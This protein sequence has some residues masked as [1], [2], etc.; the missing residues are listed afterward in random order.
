MMPISAFARKTPSA[1]GAIS[2]PSILSKHM[3][4]RKLHE[5]CT[6]SLPGP[7]ITGPVTLSGMAAL[8][9]VNLKNGLQSDW[10]GSIAK[11]NGMVFKASCATPPRTLANQYGLSPDQ[12]TGLALAVLQ[13][14]VKRSDF[15][16]TP[17]VL[18]LM[19]NL[20][21]TVPP[22]G[23]SLAQFDAFADAL[24]KQVLPDS[25]PLASWF[26]LP[27]PERASR[28]HTVF[29]HARALADSVGLGPGPGKPLSFETISATPFKRPDVQFTIPSV[30]RGSEAVCT[31]AGLSNALMMSAADFTTLYRNVNDAQNTAVAMILPFLV[32]GMCQASQYHKS[33]GVLKGEQRL[34]TVPVYAHAVRMALSI[35]TEAQLTDH[36]SP[37][38]IQDAEIIVPYLPHRIEALAMSQRVTKAMVESPAVPP[39][40]KPALK[41]ELSMN[42]DRLSGN[43]FLPT[44]ESGEPWDSSGKLRARKTS[45]VN[46]TPSK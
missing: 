30:N 35:A 28:L 7:L 21:Q 43:I 17:P 15:R 10:A 46:P 33:L 44:H 12:T 20:L 18:S 39:H 40:L 11:L 8:S 42:H 6:F 26:D 3:P 16:A 22:D 36:C 41:F 24:V 37:E 29:A 32:H 4:V 19:F 38:C 25:L 1:S 34:P 45:Q 2:G 31:I 27:S 13:T 5:L 14:G 9:K 23:K